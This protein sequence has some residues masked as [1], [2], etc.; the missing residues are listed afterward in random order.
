MYKLDPNDFVAGNKLMCV[1]YG[2]DD[3]LYTVGGIYAIITVDGRWVS[4]EDN[5]RAIA[6]PCSW[7]IPYLCG[8]TAGIDG[9]DIESI[10]IPLYRMTEKDLFVTLIKYGIS[11]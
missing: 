8:I 3:G 2:Y 4:M 11:L 5:E 7:P 1:Q 6:T 9:C 10:F